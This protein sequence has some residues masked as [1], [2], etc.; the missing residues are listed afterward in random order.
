[1]RRETEKNDGLRAEVGESM[2]FARA[3]YRHGVNPLPVLRRKYPNVRFTFVRRGE[4]VL[5]QLEKNGWSDDDPRVE[6]DLETG[7]KL[8]A[9]RRH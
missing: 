5:T 8:V 1:M 9:W 3:A 6:L 7:D 2:A 4:V